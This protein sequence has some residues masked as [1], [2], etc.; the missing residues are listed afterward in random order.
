MLRDSGAFIGS[1]FALVRTGAT[2]I[3]VPLDLFAHGYDV[4]VMNPTR[5]VKY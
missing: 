1:L 5:Q 2:N 3:S 4:A